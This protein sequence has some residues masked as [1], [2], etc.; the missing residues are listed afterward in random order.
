MTRNYDSLV[1]YIK[2]FLLNMMSRKG[3]PQQTFRPL[4]SSSRP[5][6]LQT[7][8]T[9]VQAS[10]R[11]VS[12]AFT[13][14]DL[15]SS[16]SPQRPFKISP[17]SSSTAITSSSTRFLT[18]SKRIVLN[19]KSQIQSTD[20]TPSSSTVPSQQQQPPSIYFLPPKA[21]SSNLA[22]SA[23]LGNSDSTSYLVTTTTESTDG[24]VENTDQKMCF[25]LPSDSSSLITPDLNTHPPHH[26]QNT[27]GHVTTYQLNSDGTISPLSIQSNTRADDTVMGGGEDYQQQEAHNSGA[28]EMYTEYSLCT[29]VDDLGG[30]GASGGGGNIVSST[31]GGTF[32]LGDKQVYFSYE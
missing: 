1:P 32:Q 29:M 31:T 25:V 18:Q 13:T 12:G 5:K 8:K 26:Q 16:T 20:S 30:E 11:V 19:N 6:I 3:A 4:V 28:E 9:S 27:S 23:A 21:S 14:N 10:Q 15:S 24:E 22:G 2:L 17:A 7:T